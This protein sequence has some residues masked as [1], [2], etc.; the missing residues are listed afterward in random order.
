M[1]RSLLLLGRNSQGFGLSLQLFL[2][3]TKIITRM[4]KMFAPVTNVGISLFIH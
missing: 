4:V 3:A 1:S 2:K